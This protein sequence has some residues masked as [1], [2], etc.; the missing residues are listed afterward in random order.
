MQDAGWAELGRDT[1]DPSADRDGAL[2]LLNQKECCM[3]CMERGLTHPVVR[4]L[5]RRAVLSA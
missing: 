2:D 1:A 4:R 5:R 3:G